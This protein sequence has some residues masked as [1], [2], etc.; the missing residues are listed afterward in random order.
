MRRKQGVYNK[1]ETG[2]LAAYS[3]RGAVIDPTPW[4]VPMQG[5]SSWFLPVSEK[6]SEVPVSPVTL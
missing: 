6:G 3:I 2:G 5:G 4:Q 1:K